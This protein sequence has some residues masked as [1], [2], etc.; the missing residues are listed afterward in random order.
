ME[1]ETA[2]V[3]GWDRVADAARM[4]VHKGCLGHEPTDKFKKSLV[5]SEHSPL[6]MLEFDITLRDVPYFAIM[7]LVRHT[8]GV[9]K[10]VATSREDR[11]GIP[12]NMRKQTD[13]VDARFA[14]NAQALINI[15]RKRLCGC[16]DRETRNVWREVA[17]SVAR[18]EP[19]LGRALVPEC[20]YRG[21]CPETKS[22]G[23]CNSKEYAESI[24]EYRNLAKK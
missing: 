15:S 23:Y 21:F 1:I 22:C 18:M 14:V 7:H 8:Q 17:A 20:V 11:T 12:R 16:A 5:V 13:F 6:R 4:T 2:R 24:S 10:F 9:E 19:I 3:T